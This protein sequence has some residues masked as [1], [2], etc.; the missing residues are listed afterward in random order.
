MVR[1]LLPDEVAE[2]AMA[3]GPWAYVSPTVLVGTAG[4]AVPCATAPCCWTSRPSLL[5][6]KEVEDLA[7]VITEETPRKVPSR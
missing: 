1:P 7:E 4:A 6:S 3:A 5:R 2:A